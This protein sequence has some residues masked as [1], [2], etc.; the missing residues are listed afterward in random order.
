MYKKFCTTLEKVAMK[1]N[2]KVK[3]HIKVDTGMRRVG[4]EINETFPLCQYIMSLSQIKIEGLYTH[5]ANANNPESDFNQIQL[6]RF[7]DVI[8]ILKKENIKIPIIHA[9][10]TYATRYIKDAHFNMVRIGLGALENIISL[11]SY[12]SLIKKVPKGYHWMYEGQFITR[13]VYGNYYS[14]WL[15]RWYPLRACK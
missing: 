10:N 5:F 7:N 13:D 15:C 3:V 11:K 1:E 4:T 8:T 9:A 6:K 2:K 12:I 14:C